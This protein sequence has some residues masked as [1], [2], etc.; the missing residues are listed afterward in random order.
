MPKRAT[1]R[2]LRNVK[3]DGLAFL[4][5]EIMDEFPERDEF[6]KGSKEKLSELSGNLD[7]IREQAFAGDYDAARQGAIKVNHAAFD[8]MEPLGRDI[9]DVERRHREATAG[10]SQFP[11]RLDRAELLPEKHDFYDAL[12]HIAGEAEDWVK[13]INAR[14]VR[15][16]SGRWSEKDMEQFE[17]DAR[18]LEHID[19]A[20]YSRKA[21][22]RKEDLWNRA[23]NSLEE[24]DGE[25]EKQREKMREERKYI[26]L[27]S[28]EILRDQE[29][30]PKMTERRGTGPM[31]LLDSHRRARIR[32]PP[33]RSKELTADA[34]LA[35]DNKKADVGK[36]DSVR[37]RRGAVTDKGLRANA[38]A[39]MGG[40]KSRRQAPRGK[41]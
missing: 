30:S 2:V 41:R 38:R 13:R 28:G 22:A 40:G 33:A 16:E 21:K 10:F 5:R 8:L 20:L 26:L 36:A 14:P 19:N 7:K 1:K 4:K 6:L 9:D 35:R 12:D 29:G 24:M 17:R 27:R 39:A 37:D 18:R 34:A 31:P 32:K 23:L 3:R 11:P 25:N 15:D